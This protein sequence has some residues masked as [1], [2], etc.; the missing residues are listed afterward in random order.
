MQVY[1]SHLGPKD[2]PHCHKQC[3]MFSKHAILSER[4]DNDRP[5][6]R[7][8]RNL[9]DL[10]LAGTVSAQRAATLFQDAAED[11]AKDVSDLAIADGK[12][13]QRDLTRRLLKGS[14]WPPLYEFDLPIKDKNTTQTALAKCCMLL[15]HEILYCILQWNQLTLPQVFDNTGLSDKAKRHFDA[16]V[17]QLGMDP[18]TTVPVGLWADGCPVKWDRSQSI[19]VVTMNFCGQSND[20]FARMRIPLCVPWL[21]LLLFSFLLPP[22]KQFPF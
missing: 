15:P 17:P 3:A 5:S 7:L 10:Y 13:S 9:A 8:R 11:G 21:H 1:T 4:K 12:H 20:Q 16:T 19:I 2:F 18:A 22:W 14:K 6:K